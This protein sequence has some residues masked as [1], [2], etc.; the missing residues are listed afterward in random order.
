M[1]SREMC[2]WALRSLGTPCVAQR[3][4]AMPRPPWVGLGLE[5]VLSMRTLPTVRR[6]CIL[7]LPFSTATPAES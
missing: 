6:R 5:R 7:P 2:G 3:V 4:C 1:P